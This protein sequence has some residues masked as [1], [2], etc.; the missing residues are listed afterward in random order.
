MHKW[1]FSN[2]CNSNTG[3][4]RIHPSGRKI[5]KE[6]RG[7]DKAERGIM[8]RG[9]GWKGMEF[10]VQAEFMTVC[11]RNIHCLWFHWDA[12]CSP[13]QRNMKYRDEIWA[14]FT[15]PRFWNSRIFPRDNPSRRH[16][17]G[18]YFFIL[19]LLLLPFLW[20]VEFWRIFL[21]TI[22]NNTFKIITIIL[23]LLYHNDAYF[24]IKTE[25]LLF[26][27]PWNMIK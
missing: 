21:D 1:L 22:L 7:E 17:G 3:F 19:L 14:K 24:Y 4:V 26:L 8:I 11:I 25:N 13:C 5:L 27:L 23:F 10:G 12:H 18:K 2:L 9:N 16:G 6:T 20:R 15:I